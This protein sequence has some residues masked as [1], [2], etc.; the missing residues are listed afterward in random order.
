M[1][2]KAIIVDI[3]STI[4]YH[5]NRGPFDWSD[6]SGDKIIPQMDK[7]LDLLHCSDEFDIF[8]VSGRPESTRDVTQEY[9]LDKDVTYNKL[10]L[11]QGNPYGKS[12]EHKEKTLLIIQETHD[13][14]M[15]FE[16]DLVC[17]EM[18]KSH[19]IFTLVPI[20]YAIKKTKKD[21][22]QGKLFD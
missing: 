3:D 19:G 8:L 15:A 22:G 1:K 5:T 9:L 14:F 18:Y 4:L 11:K 2:P 17:A 20:N 7:L 21:D 6:V 16:D 12:V 13:V 10:F